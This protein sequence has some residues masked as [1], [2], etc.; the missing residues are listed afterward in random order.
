MTTHAVH[1]GH[2]HAAPRRLPRL[3]RFVQ[4]H[5]LLLPAGAIA[6]LAWANLWPDSY[7]RFAYAADFWVND[8][9]M[10]CFFAIITK[11]VVESTVPGGML[12]TWRRALV[13]MSAACGACGL[14]A[15]GYFGA[16]RLFGETMLAAGWPA[17]LATDLAV[18]YFV[19]RLVFGR[20]P[21]VPFVLLLGLAANVV[22]ALAV[23][24]ARPVPHA[25]PG[26][27]M[28]LMA[29]ALFAAAGLRV[30]RT[31]RF[32]PY[33]V[34]AGPI[35]WA[36]LY[37]GGVHPAFALIPIVPF[38][39]HAKRDPGFFVDAPPGA[40]D[41]LSRFDRFFTWP[42]QAALLLFGLVNAGVLVRGLE[43]GAWALPLAA[44]IGKPL[45][46]IIGVAVAVA[47]GLHMPNRTGWRELIVIGLLAGTGFTMALFFAT[48]ALPPGQ[49]L[50]ETKTGALASLALALVAV[51]AA[52]LLRVGRFGAT[53]GG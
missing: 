27:G 47:A 42:A 50:A 39:P 31:R 51:G 4:E 40:H 38:L 28:V 2:V 5:L 11:E 41:A 22:G 3:S 44:L 15:L 1:A 45:G 43:S 37:M 34:L 21:A 13:P 6:A 48:A 7:F 36:A 32:A 53:G 19:A 17:V 24:A 8:V 16:I 12:H 33:I 35:A 23:A 18:S 46:V 49:L 10:V 26:V 25:R 30:R 29:A 20:H 52:R 9:A 14:A